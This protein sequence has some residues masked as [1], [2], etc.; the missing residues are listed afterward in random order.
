MR[1]DTEELLAFS[2]RDLVLENLDHFVIDAPQVPV[3]GIA[4]SGEVSVSLLNAPGFNN[5]FKAAGSKVIWINEPVGGT[6]DPWNVIVKVEDSYVQP[7]VELFATSTP[8]TKT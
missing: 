8:S 2:I 7:S 4:K 6:D 5:H 3:S 1:P